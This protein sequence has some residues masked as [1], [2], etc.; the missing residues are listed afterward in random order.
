M[1]VVLTLSPVGLADCPRPGRWARR[2]G[3]PGVGHVSVDGVRAAEAG[4]G[5][6]A[7][8]ECAVQV[9]NEYS[10]TESDSLRTA[11][12]MRSSRPRPRGDLEQAADALLHVDESQTI[13]SILAEVAGEARESPPPWRNEARPE[14]DQ[15]AVR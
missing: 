5:P 7:A 4:A 13:S 15:I 11:R 14:E 2:V 3:N 10:Q 12:S 1:L 6:G 8:A 9:A